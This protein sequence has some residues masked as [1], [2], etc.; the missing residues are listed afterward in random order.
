MLRTVLASMA[1]RSRVATT[2]VTDGHRAAGPGAAGPAW[3]APS[4][5]GAR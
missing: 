1:G 2:A 4:P 5:P 3:A